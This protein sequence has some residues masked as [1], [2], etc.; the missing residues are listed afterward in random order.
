MTDEI[1]VIL[2]APIEV[3]V[4]P[5]GGGSSVWGTVSGDIQQQQDLIDLVDLRASVDDL[6]VTDGLLNNELSNGVKSGMVL[7][8]AADPTRINI[9]AGSGLIVD[10]SDPSAPVLTPLSFVGVSDLVLPYISLVN[11]TYIGITSAGLVIQ[12][13]TDFTDI[14]R[15]NLIILGA[16][17]HSN[18]TTVN[19]VNN[20]PDV[21]LSATSQINDL[22]TGLKNFNISGNIITAHGADLSINKSMGFLFKKGSN[23]RNNKH[24]PHTNFLIALEAPAT[25][26][27]RLRDG[28]EYPSTAVINPNN[29]DLNGV[30]T[31]VANNRWS[32]QRFTL[33]PSNL[34]RIQYGQATYASKTEAI[35]AISTE[36]FVEEQNI[37]EN[38]L[39]RAL[40]VVKK[41]TLNLSLLAEAQFFEADKFGSTRFSASGV[42]VTTMQQ[43]Y[44]N[45]V[46]PQIVTT[47][48]MGP[49]QIQRGSTADT[50]SVQEFLDGAGNIRAAIAGDGSASFGNKAAGNYSGFEPDG[51]YKMHGEATTYDDISLSGMSFAPGGAAAPDIIDFVT[52]NLKIYGFDGG[53]TPERLY[54]TSESKHEYE[55]GS[56]L[57]FHVHWA[58]TT[59]G[60]G[61]VK[62]QAYVS[63]MSVDGIFSAP[64]LLT[65]IS[66]ARGQAWQNTYISLGT[67]PGTGRTINSQLV[68][69]IF[70]DPTDVADTYASDAAFI[71]FGIHYKK[72]T[73]GS[74]TR[75]AK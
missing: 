44:N 14:Q 56:E 7:S 61:N 64:T 11:A 43:A 72:D 52:P 29:Y 45:S 57:E 17:I 50:D 19:V 48:E 62:W 31:P 47:T 34:I 1:E 22:M 71:A 36:L 58:P 25:L 68:I 16:A 38:G 21:A 63:W 12:Q 35:Q 74:R 30:L 26:R 42:A 60:A 3:V 73:V 6:A 66:P 28:T 49:V 8:V 20:L 33:F 65:G 40:L 10:N 27:Y 18:R 5:G 75:T 4:D 70:R 55:E 15:R 67:M 46:K 2:P 23:F 13:T 39:L 69:Q 9:S 51:T 54:I 32:I 24:S 41:G 53:S 37:A 59:T